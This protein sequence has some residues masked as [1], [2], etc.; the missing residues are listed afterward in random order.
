MTQPQGIHKLGLGTLSVFLSIL[1]IVYLI[2]LSVYAE[3]APTIEGNENTTTPPEQTEQIKNEPITADAMFELTDRREQSV[4]HFRLSDGSI[5]A[6]QYASP[7][8]EQD[9]NGEWQDIDNTLGD[10]GNE[11]ATPNARVK[12]AK[13]ITGKENLFSLHD[14]KY[15]ITMSLDGAIKKTTGTVTN[16]Q[17]EFDRDA[18]NLQKMM[19]L[20]KLSAKIMYADILDGVD[21]EYVLNSVNVKENIIVKEKKDSYTYTFTLDLN[22]LTAALQ[23]DGSIHITDPDSG[24]VKYR[25]PAPIVY[26]AA[27]ITADASLS[28][29]TLTQTGNH[30][31]ALA[32][33]VNADWMNA[34]DRAFP[35]TVDPTIEHDNYYQSNIESAY[36]SSATS[37]NTATSNYRYVGKTTSGTEYLTYLKITNLPELPQNAVVINAELDLSVYL[38]YN[39]PLYIGVKRVNGTWNKSSITYATKPSCSSTV[40]DNIKISNST[41]YSLNVTTEVS[42]WIDGSSNYGLQLELLNDTSNLTSNKYLVFQSEQITDIYPCFRITYRDTKGIESYY[43]YYTASAGL[44]GTG[45]VNSFTG[46]LAFVHSSLGTT[47]EI[48]PYTMSL[49]YN[50]CLGNQYYTEDNV[51]TPI[52]SSVTGAGFKLSVDETITPITVNDE[53]FYVWSDADGTEHYFSY[54]TFQLNGLLSG[55]LMDEDGLGLSLSVQQSGDTITGYTIYDD[56][57]NQKHFNAA[58]FLTKIVDANGN[59]RIFSR[60]SDNQVMYIALKPNGRSQITQL[61]F[62]YT[63][64]G[65][66]SSIQNLQ[67]NMYALF[68]YTENDAGIVYLSQITYLYTSN[69]T[70]A[71]TYEYDADGKLVL[72]RDLSTGQALGFSYR[73]ATG[74]VV[75]IQQYAGA[76]SNN[77][78]ADM[79]PG[80]QASIHTTSEYATYHTAGNDGVLNSSTLPSDDVYT[81]YRFDNTGKVTSAYTRSGDQIYGATNYLHEPEESVKTKNALTS[82]TVMEGSA[83]NLLANPGLDVIDDSNDT[84]E[85]WY[86]HSQS[87]IESSGNDPYI[88]SNVS[89]KISPTVSY[90]KLSRKFYVEAGTYTASVDFAWDMVESGRARIVIYN[91]NYGMVAASDYFTALKTELNYSDMAERKSVTFTTTNACATSGWTLSV[92]FDSEESITSTEYLG[93]D[94]IMLEKGIAPSNFSEIGNGGFEYGI[95]DWELINAIIQASSAAAFEGQKGV[96]ILGAPY[97][98]AYAKISLPQV[99]EPSLDFTT[100]TPTSFVLSGWAKASSIVS[101]ENEAGKPAFAL[102]AVFHYRNGATTE[103]YIPFDSTQHDWQYVSGVVSSEPINGQY[104]QVSSVDVYC[105]YDYNDNTAYF[106]GISLVR[107]SAQVTNYTYN[108]RGHL[109]GSTSSNGQG[110]TLTYDSAQVNITGVT[111]SGGLSATMEYDDKHRVTKSTDHNGSN[112]YSVSYT[113]DAYG[114]VTQTTTASDRNPLYS[115]TSTSQY[116]SAAAYFGAMTQHTDETGATTQYFY[117]SN[118]L[119]KGVI[120]PDGN[121]LI[122]TYDIYGQLIGAKPAILQNGE[123]VENEELLH[124]VQYTYDRDVA[125]DKITTPTAK[126]E[127]EY[128]DFGNTTQIMVN[129]TPLATYTYQSGNGKLLKLTYG[130]HTDDKP[131]YVEYHYDAIDRISGI[132]YNGS[133]QATF[134]YVYNANGA[135]AEHKDHDN[136]VTYVYTYDASGRVTQITQKSDGDAHVTFMQ[137]ITYD[138]QGRTSGVYYHY[139]DSQNAPLSYIEYT[140]NGSDGISLVK[141]GGLGA[142]LD[143]TY[144]EFGRLEYEYLATD[145]VQEAYAKNYYY[146]YENNQVWSLDLYIGD[147]LYEY[148]YYYDTLGNINEIEVYIGDF[149]FERYSYSYDSLGQLIRENN[150]IFINPNTNK[151]IT[152]EY[153]TGGNR[154]CQKT[155]AYTKDSLEG[156]EYIETTYSYAQNAPSP[157]KWND[158][159]VNCAGNTITTDA[160]GNTLSD[161]TFTY[162]WQHGRQLASANRSGMSVSY[163]YNA[164]GIRTSKTVNGVLHTYDLDG[165]S[166]VRECIYDSTG[167]YV[168][169]ELRYYYDAKGAPAAMHVFKRTSATA[170]AQEFVCYFATNLQGDVVA[171]YDNAGN[172]I[173][174]YTYDAWGNSLGEYSFATRIVNNDED[175]QWLMNINPFRYRGYF[176]DTETGLYYLQ[177]RYYN[178]V[179]G[180]FLSIDNNFST[181]NLFLYCENNPVNRHDPDGEHWYYLWLDDLLDGVYDLMACVSDIVFGGAA[182]A[183]YMTDPS[184]ALEIWMSRPYQDANPSLEMQ[185]FTRAIYSQD[186]VADVSISYSIP[187]T[188]FYIKAGASKLLSPSKNIDS[189]YLHIGG[190]A[191]IPSTQVPVNISASIGI[192][193]GIVNKS[194][195]ARSFRNAGGSFIYGTDYGFWDQTASYSLTIGTSYGIYHGY[196]YYWCID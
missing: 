105:C 182:A 129:D 86:M 64:S 37:S 122:Y 146:E 119:L 134:E 94:S 19:T 185:I 144:D 6:A 115:M 39:G 99:N 194:S 100:T 179:W 178:S 136:E 148:F 126:Y 187:K 85:G 3:L 88:N 36:V 87:L 170:A 7:I 24:E 176:Y 63:D 171:L 120:G 183:T 91:E 111:T 67:T 20:D 68:L 97:A 189:T 29:Y 180:R 159:L 1:M 5:V 15:K 79:T 76:T 69:V 96:R 4:K 125:L 151:T 193:K 78:T 177:S 12:F 174:K 73:A 190:G 32:V 17:T 11:Y 133:E 44:P 161:G 168:E 58:G 147:D 62:R 92:E 8:H 23:Q 137:E 22:N 143:Y 155:Y 145:S 158:V 152:Y 106:D 30:T 195:Y 163:Q 184:R 9:E 35:V 153:D 128:D 113:Y 102:K 81:Y 46:N 160:I 66:L 154:I 75:G 173:A 98:P 117:Q 47:D 26:D 55:G 101:V 192:A 196:D 142:E 61:Y 40:L 186:Y 48:M 110:T 50:S 169:A 13:K 131:M 57:G 121:G 56:N 2:P 181:V 43:S 162:T 108:E 130:N 51:L 89:L 157:N 149:L 80:Q 124:Q 141:L 74:R 118:G 175:A 33:T 103:E 45:Y 28:T 109:I 156:L 38:L 90:A 18:T 172:C 138:S 191:S 71:V 112:Y 165:T 166:I 53:E 77:T 60:N 164:D 59:E 93:V 21:L 140:Y 107:N 82:V 84:P 31:Y 10:S 135:L 114:N 65:M 72:V 116:A 104:Y 27:G 83:V 54:Q 150:F 49:T 123:P 70:H 167:S 41:I 139:P 95:T 127:F 14:G 52:T 132:C 188:P 16:T 25:M 34:E 42:D